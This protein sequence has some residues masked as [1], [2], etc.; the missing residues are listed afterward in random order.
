MG[1]CDFMFYEVKSL[2]EE[3]GIFGIWGYFDVV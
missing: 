1:G 3:C 2:N